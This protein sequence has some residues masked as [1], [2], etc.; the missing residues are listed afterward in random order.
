MSTMLAPL[1]TEERTQATDQIEQFI[2]ELVAAFQPE[3]P[4]A[5]G[6]R[7]RPRIVPALCLWTG[8][9][10]CVLRG[11]RHQRALWRLLTQGALWFYPRFAVTD[12]AIYK[13]LERD[14]TAPLTALLDQI[15]AVLR[16]RVAPYAQDTLA[17]F[18]TA[19]F[20]LDETTLDK[21]ARRLPA[22]RDLPPDDP[23]RLGGTIAG[24][25]DVRRQLWH[26]VRYRTD[27]QQNEKVLAQEMVAC[28]PTG[29][30]I[31]ADLGYFGFPWFD[32][33][34]DAG[35]YWISRLRSKTSYTIIHTYYRRGTTFDGVVWL[36]AYRAD[37]AKHAVRLIEFQV[38]SIH[39]RYLTNVLDP[40]LLTPKMVAELYA[41]RWDF[42]LAI[43]T[44]KTHLGL[45][46]LWSGKAV[47]IEQQVLAVIII[48]QV[49]QALRLEIAGRAGVDPFD[50]S[51]PLLIEYLPSFAAR[52]LDPVDAFLTNAREVGFIRPSSRTRIQA[53][54]IPPEH[55][56]PLPPGTVLERTPRY[57]RRNC[58]PRHDRA[59]P[60]SILSE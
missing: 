39:Y 17:P 44:G 36:G 10:I 28:L 25:F 34:T 58:G 7:G 29:C 59:T 31:L 52:G 45:H 22:L 6:T 20:A 54:A 57:A 27:W 50:V 15:T 40:R 60:R 8:I 53:P 49:L 5:P 2:G 56:V 38:G 32:H 43:N 1:S 21:L 23:Q 3:D 14:G 4:T 16:E 47:V 24:L 51:L 35:Q 9:L 55:L 18:A 42:E 41:R 12:D 11:M 30:L 46:L 33:L 19:V 13:R 26:R 48:A 37:N